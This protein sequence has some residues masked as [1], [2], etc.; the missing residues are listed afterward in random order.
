MFEFA[1]TT[2][3]E[4]RIKTASYA[5]VFKIVKYGKEKA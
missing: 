3:L 1:C 5:G 4:A 2:A